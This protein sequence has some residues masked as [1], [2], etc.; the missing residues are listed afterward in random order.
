M[1]RTPNQR[2]A[3]FAR[4]SSG[5][6]PA[7]RD[8]SRFGLGR[9][10]TAVLGA[11]LPLGLAASL[12]PAVT[13]NPSALKA[14]LHFGPFAAGF[15]ASPV[16]AT[17]YVRRHKKGHAT[18][19]HATAAGVAGAGAWLMQRGV[20]HGLTGVTPRRFWSK[21]MQESAK[22]HV[23]PR[24][25]FVGRHALPI[26]AS[27]AVLAELGQRALRRR[28]R[29]RGATLANMARAA[30]IGAG[31]YGGILAAAFGSPRLLGRRLPNIAHKAIMPVAE[32]VLPLA[33]GGSILWKNRRKQ[34]GRA[35]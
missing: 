14:I 26:A 19:R 10:P 5:S 6:R 33:L 23:A 7:S 9:V 17:M 22:M 3:M 12:G 11:A 29:K 20:W 34:H 24:L 16:L 21:A 27:G 35:A 8:R 15:A 1:I 2:R 28:E 4:L 31:V 25:A 30:G 32:S 18:R 13:H